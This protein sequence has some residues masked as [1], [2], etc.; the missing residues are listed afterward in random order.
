MKAFESAKA[1]WPRRQT[2]RG[3]GVRISG[4]YVQPWLAGAVPGLY[5]L[6]AFVLS[7]MVLADTGSIAAAAIWGALMALLYPLLWKRAMTNLLGKFVD[8]RVLADRIEVRQGFFRK[9]YSRCHPIAFRIEPHQRGF[10]EALEEP[11]SRRSR[12]TTYRF[13]VEV[14]MQYGERRIVLAEF[15]LSDIGQAEALLARLQ[16]A[17]N[18]SKAPA[19]EAAGISVPTQ[20][21]QVRLYSPY[22]SAA[23]L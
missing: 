3:G 21:A 7:A 5:G 12:K 6:I 16:E 19:G 9:K 11:K 8:V 20:P 14:V 13:A 23:H 1:A 15:R 10:D 17:M 22:S 4:R 2:I 18:E